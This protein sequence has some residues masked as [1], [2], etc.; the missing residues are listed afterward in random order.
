[1]LDCVC[2]DVLLV[3]GI[4]FYNKAQNY[5]NCCKYD[6]CDVFLGK[7]DEKVGVKDGF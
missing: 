6:V 7:N 3:W 5:A 1:M 4:R 2:G